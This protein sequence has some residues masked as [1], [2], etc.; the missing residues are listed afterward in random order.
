MRLQDTPCIYAESYRRAAPYPCHPERERGTWGSG[1]ARSTCLPHRPGPSLTLGMTTMIVAP[2]RCSGSHRGE[3]R[4]LRHRSS[5]APHGTHTALPLITVQCIPHPQW[6]VLHGDGAGGV[7]QAAW[8]F[9]AT[10]CDGAGHCLFAH[11]FVLMNC[12]LL[13]LPPLLTIAVPGVPVGDGVHS[14]VTV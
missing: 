8:P 10:H 6:I 5:V 7:T 4:W 2:R 1:G 3:L 9:C 11:V 14:I 13:A 12:R